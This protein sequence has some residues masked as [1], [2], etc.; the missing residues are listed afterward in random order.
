MARSLGPTCKGGGSPSA[1]SASSHACTW[2]PCSNGIWWR[3]QPQV[4]GTGRGIL[5]V[6]LDIE[7]VGEVRDNQVRQ[8]LPVVQRIAGPGQFTC[9]VG[10][11]DGD[12]GVRIDDVV[13]ELFGAVH[14]LT[15]T[16]TALARRMA[17]CAITSCGQFA[18]TAPPIAFSTPSPVNTGLVA[19]FFVAV[20]H[21]SGRCRKHQCGLSG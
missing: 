13:F 4:P 7:G 19:L 21:R 15:G 3:G 12:L 9:Q 16:T 17:K 8:A 2:P 18:C 10:G 1:C 14:G 5:G 20:G 6:G 11:G